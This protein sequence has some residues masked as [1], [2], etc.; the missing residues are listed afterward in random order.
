MSNLSTGAAMGR[1][2]MIRH[3]EFGPFTWDDPCWLSQPIPV[4]LFGGAP[5]QI[6]LFEERDD[7][8]QA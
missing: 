1:G 7:A 3:T 8:D 4:P 5:V 6:Q 2:R